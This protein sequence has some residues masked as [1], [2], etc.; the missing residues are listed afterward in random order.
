MFLFEEQQKHFRSETQT[1]T[2]LDLVVSQLKY[3]VVL[4]A[5][6]TPCM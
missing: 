3:Q 1:K 4:S 6:M 2:I 5:G